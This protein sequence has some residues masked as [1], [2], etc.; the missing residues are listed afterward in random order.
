MNEIAVKFEGCPYPWAQCGAWLRPT[1]L[2]RSPDGQYA[3]AQLGGDAVI[4]AGRVAEET[5]EGLTLTYIDSVTQDEAAADMYQ[6]QV[7]WAMQRY[8]FCKVRVQA[9]STGIQHTH[10]IYLDRAL[11]E[12][13]YEALNGVPYHTNKNHD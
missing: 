2:W 5:P 13:S 8:G 11:Y 1:R 6:Y 7:D 10:R 3:A 4:A 9:M 12:R